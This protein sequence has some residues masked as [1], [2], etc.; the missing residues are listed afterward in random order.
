MVGLART[1][2]IPERFNLVF[3][4]SPDSPGRAPALLYSDGSNDL[5]QAVLAHLN[6]NAPGEPGAKKEK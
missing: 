3:N 5:T 6:I 1:I 4:A 2:P